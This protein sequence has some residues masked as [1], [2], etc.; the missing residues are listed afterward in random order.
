MARRSQTQNAAPNASDAWRVRPSEP[1]E[2]DRLREALRAK[3]GCDRRKLLGLTKAEIDACA[4][5]LAEGAHSAPLYPVIS[6]KLKK[7][8][9]GEFECP[10][11][12]AWCE[13]R[14]GKAPYPGLLSLGRKAKRDEWD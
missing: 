7:Q 14:I 10:K 4:E 6:P 11:D 5:R 3:L 9:D 8:F 13:Y 1:Q 2:V 12:D